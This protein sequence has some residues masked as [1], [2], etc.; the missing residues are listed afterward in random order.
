VTPINTKAR[1][2]KNGANRNGR[3]AAVNL[4]ESLRRALALVGGSV[5]LPV[6][7]SIAF[8]ISAAAEPP[9]P[10][11]STGTATAIADSPPARRKQTR[12]D[13]D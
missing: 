3:W 10:P 8:A 1:A 9:C 13:R 5:L 4:R 12:H 11:C 6:N 7:F 2:S